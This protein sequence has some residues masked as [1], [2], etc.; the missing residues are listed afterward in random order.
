MREYHFSAEEETASPSIDDAPIWDPVQQIYVGGRVPDTGDVQAL[1]AANEGALNIFGYGSLC[2]KPGGVLA[3]PTVKRQFGQA[4]GYRRCWAQ[5]S[6]DHRG[7]PQ[8]PGIVCTLLHEDE[9]DQLL[10]RPVRDG[11]VHDISTTC[12]TEGVMY[13]VPPPLVQECLDELDFREKGGYAR[14]VID[15]VLDETGE[16]VQA[17]L[18]RGTPDN[19]AIWPRV[20]RDH[21]YAAAVLTVAVGPSGANTE[22]LH[23]LNHFLAQHKQDNDDEKRDDTLALTRLVD[24][25][26]ENKTQ[27]YF[28]Y[29]CGSNQHNQLLL[30]SYQSFLVNNEE[31][32]TLTEILL[33]VPSVSL[34]NDWPVSYFAGG[35]HSGLLT[36]AGRLFLFGWNEM[37]QC[38]ELSM[39][40]DDTGGRIQA[41]EFPMK[42]QSCALGFGHTLV[43]DT[44]GTLW[45]VG[46]NEKGQ[47]CNQI[48]K[49][50]ICEPIVPVVLKNICVKTMA[51]GLFHSVALTDEGHVVTWGGSTKKKTTPPFTWI[52]PNQKKAVGVACGR[53]F[54]ITWLSDGTIWSWGSDNKYGQLGRQGPTD[55]PTAV[56]LPWIPTDHH[57][58]D[59]QCG[60]SHVVVS[61][62]N[63]RSHRYLYGWGRNDKG[64][65][66]L[67]HTNN[68]HKPTLIFDSN[69]SPQSFSCGSEFTVVATEKDELWSCGWNEH[70][71]LGYATAYGDYSATWQ[72]L[73]HPRI[74]Q[75]PGMLSPPSM[76]N[77]PIQVAAGGSHFLVGRYANSE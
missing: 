67:D 38:G 15:V 31:A 68:V 9:V 41:W 66:G 40:G 29:G 21:A 36:Q 71:N 45:A 59:V 14:E 24:T 30:Q 32:H 48:T 16:Q 69:L 51:A 34:D 23:N 46:G 7:V 28:M 11:T 56:D 76:N 72:S 77:F 26:V 35:G 50:M 8:F 65:L 37:G 57:I 5:K 52:P 19:P 12:R 58:V 4:L 39:V 49:D 17:A 63:D 3:D 73:P 75:P 47:I 22:Y 55:E 53:K 13:T 20:L 62:E 42:A 64:Q 54:S 25:Y 27:F 2:W 1:I 74:V 18:Y 60:W 43:L 33:G 6:T 44:N 10:E 61:L 70:G